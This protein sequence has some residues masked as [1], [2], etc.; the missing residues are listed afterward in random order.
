LERSLSQSANP[1]AHCIA[2][3]PPAQRAVPFVESQIDPHVSQFCG[4]RFRSASHPFDSSPSQ[5]S[6]PDTQIHTAPLHAEFDGQA[7]PH[8]PQFAV[9]VS[10][11]DSHPLAASPS[12]SSN[13]ALQA[14]TQAAALQAPLLFGGCVHSFPH[15]PQFSGSA[16][17]STQPALHAVWPSGQGHMHAPREQTSSK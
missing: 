15:A 16:V 1:E 9:S 13:P 8:W 12:Q 4:S 10:N 7:A 3:T 6:N 14:N 17:V 5:S 2:Q 11:S